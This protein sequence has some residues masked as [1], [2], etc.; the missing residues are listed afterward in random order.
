[1]RSRDALLVALATAVAV[2]WPAPASGGAVMSDPPDYAALPTAP[3]RIALTGGATPDPDASHITLWNAAGR[4][5]DTGAPLSV[6]GD[7]LSRP[8]TITAAGNYTVTYHMVCTDG[9]ESVGAVH[10]SVGTGV[11]PAAATAERPAIDPAGAGTHDHTGVDPVGAALLAVD[12]LVL[13]AAVLLLIA[14]PGPRA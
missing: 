8:V 12:A 9:T 7:V 13:A 5:L 1:M 3:A 2:L 6:R 11:P 14:K 10:F 4:A